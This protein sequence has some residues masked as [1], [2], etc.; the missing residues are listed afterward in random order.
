MTI[1]RPF[2]EARELLG[3]PP[4]EDPKALKQAYRRA[5]AAHPPDVDPEAFR[6]VRE[7]YELLGDPAQRAREILL[8]PLPAI[9]LELPP[10]PAAVPASG[11]TALA[12]LRAAVSR[13]DPRA[14]APVAPGEGAR[15]RKPSARSNKKASP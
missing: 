10:P 11:A 3:A 13:I 7:A 8:H 14:R 4:G 12:V 9:A 5:A 1:L 15:P 6:R 2:L